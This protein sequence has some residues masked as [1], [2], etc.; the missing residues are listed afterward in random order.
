MNRSVLQCIFMVFSVGAVSGLA[1]SPDVDQLKIKLQQLEQS[2]Q[3]LKGQIAAVEQA[4]KPPGAVT[5]TPAPAQA[6]PSQ[7]GQ[8]RERAQHARKR[9]LN[10]PVLLTVDLAALPIYSGY[11]QEESGSRAPVIL[12]IVIALVVVVAGY[13]I[14]NFVIKP[15]NEEAARKELADRN[16]KIKQQKEARHA[17]EPVEDTT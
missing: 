13:L 14:Y 9:P 15:K 16:L 8:G 10:R 7:P 11:V 3:E 6:T 4:Q 5:P 1:Q 17:T 12:G 2:M